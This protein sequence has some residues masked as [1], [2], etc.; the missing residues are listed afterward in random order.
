MEIPLE[1]T[2]S[3]KIIYTW[4]IFHKFCRYLLSGE[5]TQ[6]RIII[7]LLGKLTISIV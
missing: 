1:M 5:V 7:F 6:V 3:G 4:A 2:L